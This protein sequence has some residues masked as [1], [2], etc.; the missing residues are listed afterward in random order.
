MLRSLNEASFKPPYSILAVHLCWKTVFLML[1][2]SARQRGDIHAI[3]PNSVTLTQN[4]VAPKPC[5]GYLPKV[6]SIAEGCD[7]YQ[8]IVV[9]SLSAFV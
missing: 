8:S 5:P 9:M 6:R 4:A 7:R 2:A 1:L 3:H